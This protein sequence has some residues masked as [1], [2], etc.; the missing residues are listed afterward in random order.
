M[1]I[2]KHFFCTLI[3]P[4]L[5]LPYHFLFL[6]LLWLKLE[7]DTIV[8][9][10]DVEKGVI[11][12]I[13]LTCKQSLS[14]SNVWFPPGSILSDPYCFLVPEWIDVCWSIILSALKCASKKNN[15][16]TELLAR[17]IIACFKD[18]LHCLNY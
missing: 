11:S 18:R 10:P 8:F 15:F 13:G 6:L 14:Y 4:S 17:A 9:S 5:P 12:L 1:V 7:K 2:N 16:L 3:N